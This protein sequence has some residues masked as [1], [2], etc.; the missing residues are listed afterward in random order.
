VGG[1][2]ASE[3][4]GIYAAVMTNI[5][6]RRYAGLILDFFGVLTSNMVEVTTQFVLREKL[7]PSAFLRAWS[8]PRGQELYRALE[9]GE[10]DQTAWNTGFAQLIGAEP[11]NL[12]ERM[13][14][15]LYPAYD[16]LRVV[17]EARSAGVRTAVVSN[18]MGRAP[19][20]PYAQFDLRG[21]FDVV[22][23]SEERGVRKPDPAI[24]ALALEELG[25]AGSECVFADD[26]EENLPPAAALGMTV[27]HA[28]DE[29]ETVAALR[30][31]LQLP[32]ASSAGGI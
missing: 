21:T 11:Q 25:V 19:F 5:A 1:G 23:L 9:L 15:E 32:A 13:F 16:L 14:W 20:D 18:S 30:R 4:A 24:F 6:G 29:R 28:L 26:S 22:V 17:R 10:I 31:L 3:A 7:H 12:M 2:C 8:D 27:I